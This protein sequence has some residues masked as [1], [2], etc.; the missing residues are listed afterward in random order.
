MTAVPPFGL[1]HAP[2]HWRTVD[3]ISDLHLKPEEP[4]TFEAWARY[5]AQTR[6]DAVIILGDLFEAWVG[7]DAAAPGS[8]EARCGAVLD[9]CPADLAFM[10]GNRDFLV[11]SDFLARH[12]M[13][14]LADDPTVLVLGAQ[15]IV[16]SHGDLLCT[17]DVAYQQF[18]QQVRSSD[19]QRA[20]LARPLPE[21]QAIARQMREHSEARHAATAPADYALTNAELARQWLHAAS[22][23][24][25]I[26]G[27]THQP[28]DHAL[29]TGA[30]G[31]ALTQVVLS[32]WHIDARTHRAQVLRLSANGARTRLDPDAAG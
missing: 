31:H 29:G 13:R 12:G 32:D 23:R 19:W 10:R 6:A 16:L 14:D 15:R 1:L 3:F 24:T 9:A 5:M 4:A 28:A 30:D 7:D 18:R 8:F 2:D 20:F 17:D 21:R 27:H 22:A 11:G 25:L 26:H